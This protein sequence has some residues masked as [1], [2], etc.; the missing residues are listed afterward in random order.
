LR[1]LSTLSFSDTPLAVLVPQQSNGTLPLRAT[2]S[3]EWFMMIEAVK[4]NPNITVYGLPWS[5][6]SW[7]YHGTNHSSCHLNWVGCVN[8]TAAAEFV[9]FGL[10]A[11]A[12]VVEVCLISAAAVMYRCSVAVWTFLSD[13]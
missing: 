8:G 3:Y 4:R 13:C 1:D 7:L 2:N 10:V 12:R 5:F 9:D 11:N 6:P